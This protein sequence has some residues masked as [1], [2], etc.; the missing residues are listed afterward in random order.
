MTECECAEPGWCE[1]HKMMKPAHWHHLCQTRENYR[2]AW[3]EGRG[4]GQLKSTGE[5]LQQDASHGPGRMLAKMLGCN[6]G[7]NH[8]HTMD[9]WG[10]EKCLAEIN[11]IVGWITEPR[12]GRAAI[13]EDSARRLVKRAVERAAASHE[14]V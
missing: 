9:V 13:C 4:P 7:F 3:D 12:E 14:A 2:L 6:S 10:C 5:A 11:T 1:R 8:A